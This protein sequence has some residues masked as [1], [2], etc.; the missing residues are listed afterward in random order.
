[1]A[2]FFKGGGALGGTLKDPLQFLQRLNESDG[3][4]VSD[5]GNLASQG[6]LTGDSSTIQSQFTMFHN[7]GKFSAS[8]MSDSTIAANFSDDVGFQNQMIGFLIRYMCHTTRKY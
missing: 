8:T 2:G 5:L 3:D 4:V 6:G 7:I 1:M